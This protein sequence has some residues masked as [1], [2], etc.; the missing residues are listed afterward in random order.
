MRD[1]TPV[2]HV[3]F[4]HLRYPKAEMRLIGWTKAREL[5]KVASGEGQVFDCARWVH[6]AHD[7]P[8]EEF[9]REV[10]RPLTDKDA[11]PREVLYFNLNSEVGSHDGDGEGQYPSVSEEWA[12]TKSNFGEVGFPQ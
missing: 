9:K 8:R 12:C 5:T 7:L 4:S 6:N 10:G 2:P 11:E 3:G 1:C